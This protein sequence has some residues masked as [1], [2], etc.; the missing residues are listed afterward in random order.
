MN[1]RNVK[2]DLER[3]NYSYHLA[4]NDELDETNEKVKPW[5]EIPI[6]QQSPK[7]QENV[8]LTSYDVNK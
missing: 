8:T 5:Q 3:I 2:T 1:R 4:S 6:S 7:E